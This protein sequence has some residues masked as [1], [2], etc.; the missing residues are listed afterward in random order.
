MAKTQIQANPF[1]PEIQV[2]LQHLLLITTLVKQRIQ[3]NGNYTFTLPVIPIPHQNTD[4]LFYNI[5][6]YKADTNW[7][8]SILEYE[9][10]TNETYN[11][12]EIVND[13]NNNGL[14]NMRTRGVWTT[15]ITKNCVGC[16]GDCDLCHLCVSTTT[17]YGLANSDDPTSQFEVIIDYDIESGSTYLYGYLNPFINSLTPEQLNV[18]NEN[19]SIAQYLLHHL[20]VVP[21]PNYNPMIGGNSTQTIIDPEATSFA[22][23]LINVSISLD[24]NAVEIWNNDYDHF[25]NQMS[26]SEREIFDGLLP[27]RKMWYMVSAKKALEKANEFFPNTFIPSNSHNGKGDAFR[28]ALWNAYCTGF[29]GAN[30]AEQLTTAHEENIDI[31]NPFPDKEIEMDLFNNEKGRIIGQYSNY[32]NVI[33]NVLNSLNMGELRYL[34]NLNPNPPY[35]PTLYSSLIPTNQ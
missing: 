7:Q 11:V 20:I 28:H 10:N 29:F 1:Q 26:D 3:S 18:Y 17:T 34:N 16:I 24:I 21:I 25:R 27:N 8:W 31:I 12:K 22:N 30:L 33:Q 32:G 9:K 35:Y 4:N 19:P 5:V 14:F 13:F 2:I 23:N 15:T 6:F